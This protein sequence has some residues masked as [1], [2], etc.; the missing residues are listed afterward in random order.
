MPLP[1][2]LFREDQLHCRQPTRHVRGLRSLDYGEP[3]ANLVYHGLYAL[4]HGGV[5]ADLGIPMENIH[6][7]VAAG[8]AAASGIAFGEAR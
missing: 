8:Y 3:V 7:K 2:S 6:W 4:Q 5:E 1:K